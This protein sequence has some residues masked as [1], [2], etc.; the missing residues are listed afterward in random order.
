MKKLIILAVGLFIF[1]PFA[2][3][4][5][6]TNTTPNAS[7]IIELINAERTSRGLAP[8]SQ[9][10]LLTKA[11]QTRSGVL[12]TLGKLVHVSAPT[13][14]AWPTL[15]AVGYD[16]RSAGENLASVPPSG[17][18]VVPAWMASAAHKANILDGNFTEVGI[19]ISQGPYQGGTAYYIVAYFGQPRDQQVITNQVTAANQITSES[20][21][22]KQITLGNQKLKAAV[23]KDQKIIA[24]INLINL[25][26]QYLAILD[27]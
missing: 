22:L 20:D 25:L 2:Q 23:T 14:T 19:G 18:E 15:A 4:K 12:S 16:Y 26:K 17:M 10:S 6:Q 3:L 8:L 24:I 27:N 11:A 13:N 1:L 5:A 9:N 21:L 7:N